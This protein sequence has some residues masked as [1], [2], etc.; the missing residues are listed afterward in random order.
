MEKGNVTPTHE[1]VDQQSVSELKPVETVAAK[2]QQVD[3]AENSESKIGEQLKTNQP[4]SGPSLHVETQTEPSELGNATP[5]LTEKQT[6]QSERLSKD[7][8]AD[9]ENEQVE[10]AVVNQVA[11]TAETLNDKPLRTEC[12]E[13][14]S[15]A[16]ENEKPLDKVIELANEKVKEDDTKE[17]GRT[18]S[19][20]ITES[21]EPLEEKQNDKAIVE[22]IETHTENKLKLRTET[23]AN[24]EI[25]VE[26]PNNL[27]KPKRRGRKAT[28]EIDEKKL[29]DTIAKETIT[30]AEIP[31]QRTKSHR[32][33]RKS[34]AETEEKEPEST[35][36]PIEHKLV[37]SSHPIRS[38]RRGR[39]SVDAEENKHQDKIADATIKHTE[40]KSDEQN[41]AHKPKR[42]VNKETVKTMAVEKKMEES[43]P[44]ETVDAEDK[45]PN[46][47]P[48]EVIEHIETKSEEQP[49]QPKSKR[50]PR[51]A[52]VEQTEST[53]KKLEETVDKVADKPKSKRGRK[54]TQDDSKEHAE[55]KSEE[56]S[57]ANA[58]DLLK[59]RTRR[60]QKPTT[61]DLESK[62]TP[63]QEKLVE[64]TT[65]LD[66]PIV[67]E[68]KPTTTAEEISENT[69]TDTEK[70]KRRGRKPSAEV[71]AVEVFEPVK[72]K[73]EP[74]KEKPKRRGR[75]ASAEEAHEL[76]ERKTTR[77]TRKASAETVEQHEPA[78]ETMDIIEEAEEPLTK[79][80]RVEE[81]VVSTTPIIRRRGRRQ[82]VNAEE[83]PPQDLAVATSSRRGRKAT[84]DTETPAEPAEV[85][86]K[87]RGRKAS[88]DEAHTDD[89]EPA[90]KLA[91]RGRKPSAEV[92]H[93]DSDAT[94][95]AVEKKTATRRVRKVSAQMDTPTLAKKT[96]GR[97]GRKASVV[98]E[99]L[100]VPKD[101]PESSAVNVAASSPRPQ[102]PSSEDELTPRRREGRNLPR[103]N[104]DETS[105]EDKRGSTSSPRR[106]RKPA[107][108][109]AASKAAGAVTPPVA[110]PTT[111]I[112]RTKQEAVVES[113]VE[114]LVPHTPIGPA[115]VLP[116]PTSS[117]R[118]E[119]RNVP[120]KNYNETSDDDKPG[121]SR[122][123]R[124]RQ[125]TVKALELLVDTAAAAQRPVTPRRRK[126][127]DDGDQPPE[128]KPLADQGTPVTATKSRA[129]G[130]RKAPDPADVAEV[131][132]VAISTGK[133]V[134]RSRKDSAAS[135]QHEEQV[136]QELAP[137][138]EAEPKQATKRNARGKGKAAAAEEEASDE[139]ATKKARGKTPILVTHVD[140]VPTEE[141]TAKRAPAS[142]GRAA[143]TVK[144]VEDN[145]DAPETTAPARAGRGR[146]VHFEATEE[147]A[148]AASATAQTEAPTRSTRSRRK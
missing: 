66:R 105:D 82:S 25:M 100:E 78:K 107:A 32:R 73:E 108:S 131:V 146:K 21:C 129:G 12:L 3:I 142:R 4:Q 65:D 90:K 14:H 67:H 145:V 104:Y 45:K 119:G 16:V 17:Q 99:Q 91:K 93:P 19:L 85:K 61:A 50:R 97:R 11:I 98:E 128:K 49:D 118:R 89:A 92:E 24:I 117:Q 88:A 95:P 74:I 54:P 15:E 83:A 60:G 141:S 28:V 52:T 51:K 144:A 69:S 103:K 148:T 9:V 62:E 111:P 26:E 56:E 70:P 57:A 29:E 136:E 116:E 68:E 133:R 137:E 81:P 18:S 37:E 147:A 38:T 31:E 7:L 115:V 47:V 77:T 102:P 6:K 43:T 46:I 114:P 20:D 44:E 23:V 96:T 53:E 84:A 127:K 125:P 10:A 64:E 2:V 86:P 143:R 112:P 58:K 8:L 140:V 94:E 41:E 71:V 63:E 87:R 110:K 40:V 130:R 106:A 34:T 101:L 79:I 124:V 33:G 123:R 113:T 120:R 139:P 42:R 121:T 122:A 30:H 135:N 35:V 13:K 75:K 80:L 109:K 48:E 27:Q 1:T 72:P 55:D 134:A 138:P 59:P 36:Q 39:K 132:A 126:A 5:A 76:A 22:A